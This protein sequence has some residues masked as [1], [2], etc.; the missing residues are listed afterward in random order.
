MRLFKR[1]IMWL[2]GL[3]HKLFGD[4]PEDIDDELLDEP[5]PLVQDDEEDEVEMERADD[6][7]TNSRVI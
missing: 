5:N 4:D 7:R 1:R 6:D 2:T 3:A